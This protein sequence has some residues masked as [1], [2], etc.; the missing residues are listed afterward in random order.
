[1]M[2]KEGVALQVKGKIKRKIINLVSSFKLL[3]KYFSKDGGP[4]EDVKFI[5][6]E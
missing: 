2:G 3:R 6:S 1:M 4:Q 5:V